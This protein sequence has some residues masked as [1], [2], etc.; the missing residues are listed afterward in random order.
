MEKDGVIQFEKNRLRGR[1]GVW[2]PT[3]WLCDKRWEDLFERLNS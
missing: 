3:F 1:V 2:G